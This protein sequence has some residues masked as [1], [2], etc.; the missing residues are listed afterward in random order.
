MKLK[1]VVNDDTAYS[2]LIKPLKTVPVLYIDDFFRTGNDEAGR[3][4]AP[5]Q[6]DINVAF[7]LINYRYNNNLVTILSSEL[8]VD[9]IL[10][11]D[12]AVGSRIYQ[13]TKEYH[14]D[15]A[16]D[17]HKNHRLK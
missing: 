5:T 17:P 16:K 15:I 1:A 9:Q 4:K 10:F 11:F 7:E 2:N 14:W 8:T 6:G 3:K 13:R 12:E